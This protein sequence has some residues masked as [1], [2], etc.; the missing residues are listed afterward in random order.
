MITED[1]D[2][3]PGFAGWWVVTYLNSDGEITEAY[4]SKK[5]YPIAND[6][7]QQIKEKKNDIT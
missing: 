5:F 3:I 7:E 2:N 6:V 4:F 1:G